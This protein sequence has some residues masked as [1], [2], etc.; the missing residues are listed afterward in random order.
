M[1]DIELRVTLILAHGHR[2]PGHNEVKESVF[3][4]GTVHEKLNARTQTKTTRRGTP[5]GVGASLLAAKLVAVNST[6]LCFV[7]KLVLQLFLNTYSTWLQI[8]LR[9]KIFIIYK[10]I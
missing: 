7:R 8:S 5:G 6:R 10:E 4:E 3:A 2:P 9:F 1:E